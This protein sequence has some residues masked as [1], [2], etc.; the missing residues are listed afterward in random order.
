MEGGEWWPG[1]CSWQRLPRRER[2]SS[3]PADSPPSHP[4]IVWGSE[5]EKSERE[6]WPVAQ[7]EQKARK[8]LLDGLHRWCGKHFT[9]QT[10]F[11]RVLYIYQG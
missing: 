10:A 2:R 5:H 1:A 6:R 11:Y 8:D 3:W 9:S 4:A 7:S